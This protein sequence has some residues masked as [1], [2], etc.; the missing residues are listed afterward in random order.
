MAELINLRTARKQAKRRQ[1]DQHA[2][3]NRLSH[4]QP[5]HL[6][7]LEDARQTKASHDLDLRQIETGDGR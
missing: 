1:G 2:H 3:A 7:E 4:G 6:R 5:K